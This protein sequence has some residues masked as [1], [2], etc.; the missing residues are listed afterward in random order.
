MS[1]GPGRV[2]KFPITTFQPQTNIGMGR[3]MI[4]RGNRPDL[5]AERNV[6]L[7]PVGK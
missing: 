3:S 2:P 5:G 1:R 7:A 4:L 6:F